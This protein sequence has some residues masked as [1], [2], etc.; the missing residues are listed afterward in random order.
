MTTATK[1]AKNEKLEL[2]ILRL[3]ANGART[4]SDL[5]KKMR[6]DVKT[7]ITALKRD[8]SLES[9][10]GKLLLTKRGAGRL[11]FAS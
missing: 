4:P 7:R 1:T 3:V 10:D 11:R 8:E 2:R 5:K 9:Q 6:K